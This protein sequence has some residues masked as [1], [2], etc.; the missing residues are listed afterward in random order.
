[1]SFTSDNFHYLLKYIIIGDSAVGKSNILLRYVQNKYFENSHPTIGVEFGTKNIQFD[2]R[3][4]RIQ[5]WDTAGSEQFRSLTTLFY[6][7]CACA[8]ITYDITNRQSFENVQLWI[9]DCINN[10]PKSIT[11]VLVGNKCDLDTK[12][13]VSVEEGIGF[14]NKKG[15]NFFET[16]AKTGL[17]ITEIFQSTAKDIAKKIEEGVIE[18]ENEDCGIK[19]GNYDPLK[20]IS[21]D[22]ENNNSNLKNCSYC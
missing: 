20:A 18:L 21:L 8:V 5:I 10:S 17:N 2:D 19:I 6:K 3:V 22:K 15:I 16:S 1:M 4:F 9:E 13:V 7:N 14:A 12:R 11:I